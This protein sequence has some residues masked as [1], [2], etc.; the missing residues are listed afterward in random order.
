MLMAMA[1]LKSG[2][3]SACSIPGIAVP[4]EPSNGV[5]PSV[6]LGGTVSC[7]NPVFNSSEPEQFQYG[8]KK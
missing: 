6:C 3:I 8:W 5:R 2:S 1:M 4:F 7:L